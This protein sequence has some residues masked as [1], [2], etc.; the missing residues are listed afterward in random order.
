MNI[1]ESLKEDW[2]IVGGLSKTTKMP[3]FSFNLPAKHC[4][5]GTKLRKVKNST[6]SKC[7]AMKGFYRYPHTEETL[8]TRYHKIY[9]VG[10]VDSMINLIKKLEYTG[11][12]RW[13]DSGD[14]DSLNHLINIVKVCKALPNIKFWLP[15]REYGTVGKYVA[16][17][18]P[19]P[20]NLTVR[21]SAYMLEGDGPIELSNKLN[22]QLSRVSKTDYNCPS[23]NQGNMCLDCRKCW[24]N[25]IKTITYKL[26]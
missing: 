17:Y 21:L 26:H 22:V 14:I 11:H 20:K 6:C 4:K 16:L 19:F 3:C 1:P 23:S 8:Q 18:G 12:F 24:D 5:T 13:F 9:S 7:Y 25:S 15:T 10:W 2:Q